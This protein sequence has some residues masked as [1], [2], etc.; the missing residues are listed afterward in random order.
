MKKKVFTALGLMSGTSMDGVDISLISSDGFNE[1]TSILNEYHSFDL[2]LQNKLIDLRYKIKNSDDLKK[3][4]SEINILE[5]KITLFHY[6]LIDKI[7]KEN[8]QKIDLIGFHGQTIFHNSREK[9]S[10]QLCDGRLLSQLTKKLVI[11]NFREEDLKKDGQGA[12][13]TPIFHK[14]IS[15]LVNIKFNISFPLNIINIGGITN[16]TQVLD[17]CSNNNN[18]YAYDIAPGNCLIDEWVRKNS[19]KK[20]DKDGSLA[21][22]GKVDD[23]LYNQAIDNFYFNDYE[24]SLDIKDFDISFVKGLSLEDGCATLTKFSAHLIANGIEETNKLRKKSSTINLV[25]GGGRKNNFLMQKINENLEKNKYSK[26]ENIDNY[27]FNGDFIESQA[28]G[29]LSIRTFLNLP[30]SFPN[31]TRCK[32]ETIGGIINKNF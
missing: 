18:L 14:L 9:I 19:K 20:F 28:F 2:E 6:K 4:S 16:I 31:T 13:L 24:K 25:C 3:Y 10:K 27:G 15:N 7:L 5:R 23:L 22:S 32:N 29:Y 12:P 17:N 21:K 26:L 11:N 1:F 8:N 30:I